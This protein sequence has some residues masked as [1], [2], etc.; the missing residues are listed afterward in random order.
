MEAAAHPWPTLGVLMLRDG[1]VSKEQLEAILDEQRDSRQQRMSGH[2]L[3]E[4][5]IDR[6]LVTPTDVAKLVA[7]QYELPFTELDTTEIDL[8]VAHRFTEELA[9]RVSAIPISTRS[10]GS[11]VLA[12]ADPATV[13]FS[14]EL[15]RVLGPGLQ[16]VVVGPDAMES[17]I[18]F[19]FDRPREPSALSEVPASGELEGTLLELR[20][21]DS[22]SPSA[23][24]QT[25]PVA[26]HTAPMT[27]QSP[28]LGA[29]LVREGL[30]TE[31][32][33]DAA[34]AQQRLSTSWRLGEIL[35]N[36]GVVTPAGI[37]RVIAEQYE[38]P[39]VDLANAYVDPAVVSRLPREVARNFPAVPIA[40]CSDGS[41]QVAIADPTNVY[42]SDE[43]QGA[44][45]TTLTF[46]VAAPDAIDAVIE[47]VY[48]PAHAEPHAETDTAVVPLELDRELPAAVEVDGVDEVATE[49]GDELSDFAHAAAVVD[50]VGAE[51]AVPEPELTVDLD[52]RV[53]VDDAPAEGP[54]TESDRTDVVQEHV[55]AEY[56]AALAESEADEPILGWLP[57]WTTAI[58]LVDEPSLDDE[59]E[60][61]V[62]GADDLSAA[63]LAEVAQSDDSLD[64]HESDDPPETYENVMH[65]EHHDDDDAP[66]EPA[67]VI[68]L[69]EYVEVAD[70][71]PEDEP[72]EDSEPLS[73]VDETSE[74]GATASTSVVEPVDLAV[75]EILPLGATAVHF[76]PSG[77]EYVV[78]ARVD[79]SVR[80]LGVVS[81]DDLDPL[82]ERLQSSVPMRV[83]VMP[84]TKGDKITLFP[85]D[86]TTAPTELAELGLTGDPG[87]VVHEAL[88]R[89]SGAIVVCGP[90]GSGTTTTL[91]AA[92]A[93]LNTPDRV[94]ATIEDP[95][96][97]VLDGVDQMEVDVA[98]GVSFVDG[99]RTLLATDSDAVLVG[100]I[101]DRETA[102]VA[103]AGAL[104]GR[105]VL[106]ALRAPGAAAAI[107]RLV[108]LGLE[109][110]RICDALTCVVAQRLVRRVCLDCRETYYATESELAELGQPL[111]DAGPRL[112][113]R[114]RGCESCDGTGFRG[115]VGIFE[116]L[117][118]T[119]EIRALVADDVSTKKLQRAAVAGGMRTLREEGVRLCLD[120]VT[121]SAELQ[122][123]LGTD[124]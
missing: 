7:E 92:L 32:E 25:P 82:L 78:R 46:V 93:V 86:G 117:S 38:L 71:L 85:L 13:L 102:E 14:D 58:R 6:G 90:V 41:L 75:E 37:A 107:R 66:A 60:T 113:A 77:H 22:A 3:G 91:Y 21:E 48:A 44:L 120:G 76:S 109:P 119:D 59:P 5:L 103:F 84:T 8:R 95:I 89:P 11:C 94:V 123:V 42:Y 62:T 18:A 54:P 114:G 80:E 35:V 121:T 47:T 43:L 68:A 72:A 29:L 64:T 39:F 70:E 65:R 56:V 20:Q 122:R 4:I 98:R 34:L 10:D 88:A 26:A 118:V 53:V 108:D 9:R 24:Y 105:H 106:S 23:P 28:P 124:G 101:G 27:H 63:L 81:N 40:E 111:E 96:A 50:D 17:A 69:V 12:I 79:G 83:H 57:T 45:G 55:V 33:L 74:L 16:F 112:L 97:R 19:V 73:A 110:S 52:E 99:L 67:P 51:V 115:R 100:E 49:I 36:R 31:D 2:R 1:L 104:A 61:T 116:V 30:V 15:R 87:A